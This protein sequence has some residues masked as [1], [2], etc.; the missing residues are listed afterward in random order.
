MNH[1]PLTMVIELEYVGS[2]THLWSVFLQFSRYDVL[3]SVLEAVSV[4]MLCF[5]YS[6]REFQATR[7]KRLNI[8]TFFL[9]GGFP[10]LICP[11]ISEGIVMIMPFVSTLSPHLTLAR[12]RVTA[13]VC[14]RSLSYRVIIRIV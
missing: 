1:R 8:V 5:T 11:H 2:T 12:C 6:C 14:S 10:S 4:V 9:L 13:H 3:V 7:M